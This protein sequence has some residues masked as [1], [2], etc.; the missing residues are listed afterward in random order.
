[1]SNN[2]VERKLVIILILLFLIAG[3]IITFY[4]VSNAGKNVIEQEDEP[5]EETVKVVE[6][7]VEEIDY[8]KLWEDNKNKN[9]DYVGNIIFE[10]GLLNLPFVCPT[11]DFTEYV[12]YTNT[13]NAVSDYENGCEEGACS[14]N[15]VYLRTDWETMK[16]NLGGSLFMDYRNSLNDQNVI[17]YGHHYPTYL[18]PDRSL[19]FTPLEKLLKKENY[20]A[21]KYL[22]LVLENETKYYIVAYVYYFHLT[23]EDYEN[24]Q[25][26]RLNYNADYW[27]EDDLGYYQTYINNVESVKLYDTGIHLDTSDNTLTLQTCLE[28]DDNALEIVVCKQINVDLYRQNN[29]NN[30]QQ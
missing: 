18:D 22:K 11:K 10:S 7:K 26:Y 21:N 12:F 16:Y 5:V 2:K 20:E 28:N 25:F 30:G 3:F 8:K 19:F 13:G 23:D 29:Q 27:G 6:E 9:I 14:G 15:D 17:I 24:L 4:F 1:M